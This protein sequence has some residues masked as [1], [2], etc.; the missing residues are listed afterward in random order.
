VTNTKI[1]NPANFVV[2]LLLTYKIPVAY[3]GLQSVTASLNM[4]NILDE[5]YYNYTYSSENPVGGVYDPSLPGGEA[6]NS[7]FVGEPR[8]FELDLTAKF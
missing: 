6:Y 4:Q 7:A 5:R 1:K 2:N 8:S 3:H